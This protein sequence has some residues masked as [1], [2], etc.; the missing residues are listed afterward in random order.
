M[1]RKN[2]APLS[3]TAFQALQ[4]FSIVTEWLYYRPITWDR[5]MWQPRR[6]PR[7]K[8]TTWYFLS[9]IVSS[10]A[11]HFVFTLIRQI[12]SYQKDPDISILMGIFLILAGA[13]YTVAVSV[14]FTEIFKIDEFRV[15]LK[16]LRKFEALSAQPSDLFGLFLHGFILAVITSPLTCCS[17]PILAPTIDPT[18]LWF[19][20]ASFLSTNF[21]TMLR[22]LIMFVSMLHAC[23]EL[24]WFSIIASNVTV[25]LNGCLKIGKSWQK[26]TKFIASSQLIS[27]LKRYRQLQIFNS[28]VNQVFSYI[29]PVAVSLT[30]LC[31]VLMGYFLI[32][33][34]PIVPYTITFLVGSVFATIFCL[35][36]GM[37]PKMAEGAEKFEMSAVKRGTVRI[38]KEKF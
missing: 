16:F 1:I 21:K 2:F 33:M 3:H 34:T 27:S 31:M 6:T 11:I 7:N 29:L 38:C 13:G 12:L 20:N 28:V 37:L 8:L 26:Q 36:Q 4:R 9:L 22:A 24:F 19:R 35:G 10:I 17:V 25:I 30:F 5:P 23:S 32:K 15:M 18:Y 14:I